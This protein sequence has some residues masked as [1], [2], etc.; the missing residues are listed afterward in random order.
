MAKGVFGPLYEPK[1]QLKHRLGRHENWIEAI[2]PADAEA[3]QLESE[4]N[5]RPLMMLGLLGLAA[6]TVLLVRLFTLQIVQGQRNFTLAEGNRIRQKVVTAA[7]GVIYDRNRQV[8]VGNLPSFDVTVVPRLLPR[9]ESERQSY[10]QRLGQITGS[11]AADI[12]RK[13]EARGLHELQPQLVI[14][15]LERDK[16]LELDQVINEL[17]GFSLDV[18]PIREYKDNGLLAQFLGYTGRV[19]AEELAEAGNNYLATDYIGK[20]GLERYYEDTLRGING[21]QQTEVDATGQPVKVLASRQ[22]QAGSNLVLAVDSGLQA[23][24]AE[25]IQRQLD[26]SGA[27]KGA[28]VALHPQTGEVLAAVSLPGYDNNLFSKGISGRDYQQLLNDPGQP[29]F[30]K[31]SSGSYP[32]GSVIKPLVAAAALQEG[33]V[34]PATTVEDTGQLEIPNQYDPKTKYTFRSWEPGG[35]GVVNL[36]RALALSSNIYFFTVGGGY[37]HI[38]GLGIDRLANYYQKFGLGQETGIDLPEEAAGRVPTPAWKQQVK[39]EAWFTGDTYNVSVGQ[40]DVLVSPLQMAVAT[41]AVANGGKVL[42]PHFMKEIEDY[43]G[44]TIRKFG[45]RV[46][47][48]NFIAPEHLQL[49]REGMREVVASGTACCQFDPQIAVPVAGKTGS[50]ETDPGKKKPHAWF[51]AFAPHDNPQIVLVVLIENSGEGSRFAA[52]AVRETLAW[53]FSQPGR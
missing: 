4:T 22:P 15:K 24:L 43:R 23:K 45:T 26:A 2:L 6:M 25:S 9:Q 14:A 19:S 11:D 10:Y 50:A 27:V 13:A 1:G 29:L 30:N 36:K 46:V 35:L 42:Q 53:Y 17:S 52:P 41:T 40:G 37:G 34:T 44:D 21:S 31:V 49:V 7:R 38:A 20:L 39:K 47:R 12:G 28:G 3:G 16:A 18:N 32:S 33:V 8:I 5:R 51:S 48:E